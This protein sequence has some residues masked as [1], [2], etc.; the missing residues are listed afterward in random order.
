MITY[1][2]T[3]SV[4]IRRATSPE[5]PFCARTTVLPYS[6][7]LTYPLSIDCADLS[8]RAPVRGEL[9]YSE[10]VV[11]ALERERHLGGP[12]LVDATGRS[13]SIFLA[14]A[15]ATRQL[16]RQGIDVT[17]LVSADGALPDLPLE[18][19]V[20]VMAWPIDLD[21]VKRL[22]TAAWRHPRWGIL[23]PVITGVSTDLELVNGVCDALLALR[24]AFFATLPIEAEPQAR[25]QIAM[26]RDGRDDDETFAALFDSNETVVLATERHVAALAF[27]AGIPDLLPLPTADTYSNWN[28]ATLLARCATKMIRLERDVE[29]AWMLQR[30]ARLLA[31]L[32][33]PISLIAQAASLS[34]IEGLD[35]VSLDILQEWMDGAT[36]SFVERIDAEWRLR[37]DLYR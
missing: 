30:S 34:I 24:P 9:A 31:E 15:A 5:P 11:D 3:R 32:R 6:A 36:P 10:D 28:A 33:K 25:S 22:A 37:R 13:E 16:C 8:A 12:L 21:A 17:H 35:E 29:L 18:A 7:S 23:L 2:P 27:D 19:T 1:R 26:I 14:G 20:M 4:R